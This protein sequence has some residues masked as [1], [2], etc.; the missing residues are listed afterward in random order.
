MQD[1]LTSIEPR[2]SII[3]LLVTDMPRAYRFY[4][5]GLGLPTTRKPTDDWIAFKLNGICLA[6]Y[7][8]ARFDEEGLARKREADRVLDR[9]VMPAI[10]LAYNTRE[11]H[12]V[13]QVLRLAEKAGG[14]IEK[15]PQE[16]FW[17][18]YSGYFSDPDGHLWEVAWAKSW[19][20]NG[21]GSL[22]ID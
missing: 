6:I 3:T 16:T 11:K 15:Q 19:E 9:N 14:V 20:F 7:P 4:V 12:Q 13:E 10:G 2:V 21:D 1:E 17:G 8:Y 18:G 5:E 22:V